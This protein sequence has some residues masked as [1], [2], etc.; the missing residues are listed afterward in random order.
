[1]TVFRILGPI[2]PNQ[3]Q[4][5]LQNREQKEVPYSRNGCNC[6]ERTYER[7]RNSRDRPA[8]FY[9]YGIA[10]LAG[11]TKRSCPSMLLLY[12]FSQ[13]RNP[14]FTHLRTTL[15]SLRRYALQIFTLF[16]HFHPLNYHPHFIRTIPF[17]SA[18]VVALAN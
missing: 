17:T 6:I 11:F 18:G 9:W 5:L 3:R 7:R 4:D 16:N 14:Y 1:M 13:R 10:S 8:G 12:H 15:P 2:K